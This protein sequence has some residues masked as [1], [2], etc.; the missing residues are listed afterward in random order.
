MRCVVAPDS[1]KGS[2]TAV[3]VARAIDAGLRSV[4]DTLETDLVPLA[5]GGEGT[6]D[7][8]I[9]IL[10]GERVE[11]I[12]RDP[13]DRPVACAYGWVADRRLAVIEV[14]AASGLPL[15][16]DAL[17]PAEATTHGTG[18]LIGDALDRGAAALILGL[19]GSATV[20]AGTG[21]LTALGARFRDARGVELRGAA[22]TLGQVAAID[23][24]G[25]DHR[26]RGLRLTLATDVDSPLLG[27]QGAVHMFGPQKGI[28]EDRLAAFEAAMARFADVVVGATGTDHRDSPGSGA[29]GGIAFLLRSVLDVEVQDGFRLVSDLADLRGR[30]AAADL[31]ITGE[32]RLDAQSLVGKVPVGVARLARAAGVPAIA[33]AGQ[34]AGDP[35]TFREA[36]LAAVVPIVDRPMT[37]PDAMADAPALI[38]AAAARLMATLLLGAKLAGAARSG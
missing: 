33:L 23:L 5:D 32:G 18:Q 16:G 22:G 28:S 36:G 17:N 6:V 30:I 9:G 38:E 11:I 25:L 29:A 8:L 7:A 2:A 10:G 4:D 21:L 12:A 13:L 31:V 15:L 26:L 14:A 34:I 20:D 35:A 27:P 1:F 19:G 3:E 37:L 24:A